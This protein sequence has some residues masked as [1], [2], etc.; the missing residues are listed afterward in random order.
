[1]SRTVFRPPIALA[2]RGVGFGAAALG[3]AVVGVSLATAFD[4][5]GWLRTTLL[6]VFAVVAVVALVVLV[7]GVVRALGWGTRLVLDDSGFVNATGPG[8]GVR[9]AAWKDVRKVQAD[10]PVVSV[11]LA[12]DRQ[13]LIRTSSLDVDPRALARELRARLNQDRGYTPLN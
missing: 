3:V 8:A 1:M 10:G 5:P 7:V 4:L 6:A 2:V 13:S 11:D 9:R 12:G